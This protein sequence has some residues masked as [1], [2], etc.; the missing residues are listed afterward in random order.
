MHP[1]KA[2]ALLLIF[3]EIP[4]PG[5]AAQARMKKDV[6]KHVPAFYLDTAWTLPA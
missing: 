6:L 5:R 3:P 1:V 2:I 4:M